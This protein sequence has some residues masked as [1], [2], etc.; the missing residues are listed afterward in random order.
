M[1]AKPCP[2]VQDINRHSRSFTSLGADIDLTAVSKCPKQS[3]R[4]WLIYGGASAGTLVLKGED[5]VNTTIAVGAN[6]ALPYFEFAATKIIASGTS[7]IARVT[8][9]WVSPTSADYNQ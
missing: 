6:Q 3:A 4:G 5:E 9:F 2:N 7:N 8:V 1:P